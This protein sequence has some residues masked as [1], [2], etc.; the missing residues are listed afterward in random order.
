[1]AS[2][3]SS[4]DPT[5]EEKRYTT[6]ILLPQ[7][8]AI[9]SAIR[10]DFT[11]VLDSLKDQLASV[12]ADLAALRL[13]Q[14]ATVPRDLVTLRSDISALRSDFSVLRSDFSALSKTPLSARSGEPSVVSDLRFSGDS[15]DLDGFLITIYDI[16]ESQGGCFVSDSRK[17]SWVARHFVLGS[18]AH[19][20][21]MSQLQENAMAYSRDH[22]GAPRLAGTHSVAGVPFYIAVLIDVSLFLRTIAQL[23]SDPYAAQTALKEFQGLSMGKLSIVQFNACFIALSFRITASKDIFMDYYKKALSPAIFQRALSRPEWEPCTTVREL[24]GVAVIAARQ[25]EAIVASH[26]LRSSSSNS[27]SSLVPVS[28]FP[29]G[30]TIPQDSSAMDVSAVGSKVSQPRSRPVT[31]FPFNF[32]R[33]LCQARG[34]CWRCQ[35][36]FDDV[37]RAN[38]SSGKPICSNSPVSGSDMDAYCVSCTSSSSSPVPGPPSSVPAPQSVAAVAV[39]FPSTPVSSYPLGPQFAP[40]PPLSYPPAVSASV[41][42]PSFSPSPLYH[43][44]PHM[45]PP[46]VHVPTSSP[47]VSGPA[48]FLSPA[49][50]VPF[51]PPP[52]AQISAVF[53]EYQDLDSPQYYDL[54]LVSSDSVAALSFSSPTSTTLVLFYVSCY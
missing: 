35:H 16:L 23:F 20:W 19:D 29:Q 7:I 30:V 15:K 11:G 47:S 38:K 43:H 18:P 5:S 46:L 48:G 8:E 44:P 32:Y 51:V 52:P 42:V 41:S 31:R 33:E 26:R 50:V 13:D 6:H 4:Y 27:S 9:T 3:S 28:S 12:T 37:H 25:E 10:D 53:S 45:P 21:W 34:I 49:P 17:V 2:H 22:A 54:P 36:T 1:M 40:A 39:P 24:M 14:S